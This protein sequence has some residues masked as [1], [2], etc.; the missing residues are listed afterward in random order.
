[1]RVAPIDACRAADADARRARDIS[2]RVVVDDLQQR[3]RR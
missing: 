1:M 3:L 2:R